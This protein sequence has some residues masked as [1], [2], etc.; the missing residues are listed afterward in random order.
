M[1]VR[2]GPQDSSLP[3]PPGPANRLQWRVRD[4]MARSRT[5]PRTQTAAHWPRTLFIRLPTIP[6]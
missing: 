1:P 4:A 5:G 2:V 6:S 3:R